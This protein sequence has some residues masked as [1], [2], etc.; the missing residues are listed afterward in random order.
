M[1]DRNQDESDEPRSLD[2]TE[3]VQRTNAVLKER[4][5]VDFAYIIQLN[6]C[7]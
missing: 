2:C 5:P 3:I 6:Y 1:S 4:I 7:P